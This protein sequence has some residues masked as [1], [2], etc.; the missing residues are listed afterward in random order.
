[1]PTSPKDPGILETR[2]D[3]E[4][5]LQHLNGSSPF[6]DLAWALKIVVCEPHRHE[7]G[8]FRALDVRL[9]VSREKAEP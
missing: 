2:R 8:M 1:M 7:L 5:R 6:L 3:L 9:R 4:L